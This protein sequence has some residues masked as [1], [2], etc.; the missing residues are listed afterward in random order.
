METLRAYL[1]EDGIT[2]HE[3]Q[4][5]NWLASG[6]VFRDL[7]T[8]SLARASGGAVDHWLPRQ[9]QAQALRR[10]QNEMQMLLYTHPLNDARAARR[11]LP[12]NSFWVSGTGSLPEGFSAAEGGDTV[13][14]KLRDASLRNDGPAWVQAWQALDA[15]PL[16]A[17]LEQARRGDPVELTLCGETAAQTFTLQPQSLWA[18]LSKRFASADVPA[19]LNSL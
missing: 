17:L 4:G 8:A 12:I 16:Q 13:L 14:D 3:L 19:L 11:L 15:G 18:R 5:G 2:L 6:A 7:P 9:T 10:L 1:L